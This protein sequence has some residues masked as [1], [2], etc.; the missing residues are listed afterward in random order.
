MKRISLNKPKKGSQWAEFLC[1]LFFQAY[2]EYTGMRLLVSLDPVLSSFS[3]NKWVE[4][5]CGVHLPVKMTDKRHLKENRRAFQNRDSSCS[6]PAKR[7]TLCGHE[8]LLAPE[9]WL[10]MPATVGE[11]AGQLA[12]LLLQAFFNW[13]PCP[14]AP[15]PLNLNSLLQQR[16]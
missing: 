6:V 7:L 3:G 5:R 8:S 14:W 2:A 15:V 9:H 12:R 10:L 4:C 16:L 13:L 1:R 11:R